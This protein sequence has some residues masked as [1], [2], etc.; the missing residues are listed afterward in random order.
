MLWPVIESIQIHKKG[1]DSIAI[2]IQ[3]RGVQYPVQKGKDTFSFLVYKPEDIKPGTGTINVLCPDYLEI[4]PLE[5]FKS[6]HTVLLKKAIKEIDDVEKLWNKQFHIIDFSVDGEGTTCY[7]NL[8]P[9]QYRRF[10]PYIIICLVLKQRGYTPVLWTNDKTLRKLASMQ[11]DKIL[12]PL[13][14]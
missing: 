5:G 11:L 9:R 4:R 10:M 8:S 12:L 6:T 2:V 1:G 7:G 13:D 14:Q 3:G